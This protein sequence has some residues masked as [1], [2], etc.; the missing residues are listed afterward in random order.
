MKYENVTEG[1]ILLSSH[2]PKFYIIVTKKD[3][4]LPM[5]AE[6]DFDR[7]NNVTM[8]IKCNVMYR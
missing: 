6:I 1:T 8:D 3:Q 5:S 2:K 7:A 4:E